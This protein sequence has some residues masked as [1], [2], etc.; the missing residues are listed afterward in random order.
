MSVPR[1]LYGQ[2]DIKELWDM[3][4][5]TDHNIDDIFEQKLSFCLPRLLLHLHFREIVVSP[6]LE[7]RSVC[8]FYYTRN[9][10]N[11]YPLDVALTEW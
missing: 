3:Q 6:S 1:F 2:T 11:R 8:H 7:P 4:I 10:E 9:N 5:L